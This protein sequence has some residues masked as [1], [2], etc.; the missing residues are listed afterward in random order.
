[1]AR[2]WKGIGG[3]EMKR[4]LLALALGLILTLV[5][6]GCATTTSG[7]L[8][9]GVNIPAKGRA[10]EVVIAASD[11]SPQDQANAD[12]VCTGVN[13]DVAINNAITSITMATM[14]TGG[15]GEVLLLAGDYYDSNPIVIAGQ[16]ITLAGTNTQQVH[17]H[18]MA[19][20]NCDM[21]Q[22][23]APVGKTFYFCQLINLY[24][25]GNKTN[26]ISGAGFHIV[27]TNG[28]V[29]TTASGNLVTWESGSAFTSAMAGTTMLIF[30]VPYTVNAV[31]VGAQTL[32]LTS[33]PGT[34]TG[35]AYFV[36]NPNDCH[37]DH[38][39]AEN[40]PGY[41]FQFDYVW[42][43][44][45]TNSL[46]EYNGWMGTVN[47]SGTTV[48][49]NSTSFNTSHSQFNT[50]WVSGTAINIA[51][52]QYT[53]Q[54]VQSATNLTLTATAGT[55]T[56]VPYFVNSPSD[57]VYFG[58]L[59]S[60]QAQ[61][62][63]LF[64]AYNAGNGLTVNNTQITATNSQL[65]DNYIGVN[66]TNNAKSS[67]TQLSNIIVVSSYQDNVYVNNY[68]SSL[69]NVASMNSLA[70]MGFDVNVTQY[71]N[72]NN[73][74]SRAN[75][76]NG[77]YVA[78]S[79]NLISNCEADGNNLGNGGSEDFYDG[80]VYN[81]YANCVSNGGGTYKTR[82][83]RMTSTCNGTMLMNCR[84]ANNLTGYGFSVGSGITNVS[85]I[86]CT[87]DASGQV[88]NAGTGTVYSPGTAIP[89]T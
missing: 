6:A 64:S 61:V 47:T 77:F 81:Q 80:G 60:G 49:W 48:T 25:D 35:V 28:T 66:L 51:G 11:S 79:N 84:A 21:I 30:N 87:V 69:S 18:R 40:N 12:S 43:T 20:A 74:H 52:T 2:L 53:V 24:L 75:Y 46:A 62:Q 17:L 58:A 56:G 54:S 9:G 32:T 65:N 22:Y 82:G 44:K 19:N 42:G 78:G 63:G 34:Q 5:C 14:N 70:G 41:G 16:G 89:V 55:Q 50:S 31:N 67:Y 23:T 7:S 3:A 10:A 39:F 57:G 73:C 1:M 13:D 33:S 76:T 59:G 86:G 72:I 26:N 36:G 83:F 15:G 45:L 71:T 68:G 27:V 88:T 29:N 37:I 8:L 85:F 4:K 38:V